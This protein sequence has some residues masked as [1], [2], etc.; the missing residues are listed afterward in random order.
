MFKMVYEP[1]NNFG[2]TTVVCPYCKKE[3]TFSST[4]IPLICKDCRRP[5][6][7]AI[8]LKR[9]YVTLLD[10]RQMHKEVLQYHFL[11][12][13]EDKPKILIHR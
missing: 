11:S 2:A 6:P 13:Y 1:N 7:D 5:W 12:K 9:G 8:I 10:D 3:F 4:I